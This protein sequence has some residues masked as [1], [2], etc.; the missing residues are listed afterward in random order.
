MNNGKRITALL[1][2]ILLL[3]AL[4]GCAP[5]GPAQPTTHNGSE[6]EAKMTDDE[7]SKGTT[8]GTET[9][10]HN[11]S[12]K[13]SGKTDDE[14]GK[15]TSNGNGQSTTDEGDRDTSD[16]GDKDT[17]GPARDPENKSESEEQTEMRMRIQIGDYSF[18]A[19][20][21]D[22]AAVVELVE[23]M[24]EGPVSIRMDDY[25]GFEK[26]GALGK[27]LTS[28]D[29]QTTTVAGDIVLYNSSNIVMFYGSNSW[30]YT[31]IGHIEDLTDWEKAL[32]SGS[33]TAEFSLA[34]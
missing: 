12:S 30:A 34:E 31:R 19:E 29:S 22:N 18:T 2:G 6:K 17:T 5:T 24:K 26:V 7:G 32:G 15:N 3:A 20:L 4:A 23:M 27:R 21:E 8:G 25:A 11:G 16:M 9:T 1:P 28:S 13:D 14:G 10:V 33:I